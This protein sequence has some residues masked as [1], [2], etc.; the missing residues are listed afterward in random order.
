MIRLSFVFAS[1]FKFLYSNLT[2]K[3]IYI[4][5]S[6]FLFNFKY[7]DIFFSFF[8]FDKIIIY[9]KSK[10]NN[11]NNDKIDDFFASLSLLLN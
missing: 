9:L 3:T 6:L 8:L 2:F 5:L 4:T 1:F 10:S 7:V 11:L